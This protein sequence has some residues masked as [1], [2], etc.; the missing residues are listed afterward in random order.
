MVALV[1]GMSS[2][3]IYKQKESWKK[4]NKTDTKMFEELKSIP[5]GTMGYAKFRRLQREA[6]SDCIPYL[7]L[8]LQDLMMIQEGQPQSYK[9]CLKI[10]GRIK[11]LLSYQNNGYWDLIADEK[12]QRALLYEI[13]RNK[14]VTDDEIFE[15]CKA[16]KAAAF[17]RARK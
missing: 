13:E 16:I 10:G 17:E 3:A 6:V 8:Q 15:L 2:L 11:Y 7:G 9:K 5:S 12:I 4:L 14:D 1:S